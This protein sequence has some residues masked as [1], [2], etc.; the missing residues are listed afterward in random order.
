MSG[1]KK[2]ILKT[3]VV[4]NLAHERSISDINIIYLVSVII[5][6]E[7]ISIVLRISKPFYIFC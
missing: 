4:A 5:S 6:K 2:S 1:V 7:G 3:Y